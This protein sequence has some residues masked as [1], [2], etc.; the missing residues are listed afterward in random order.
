MQQQMDQIDIERWR[1]VYKSVGFSWGLVHNLPAI[2]LQLSLFCF[3]WSIVSSRLPPGAIWQGMGDPLLSR[4][5]WS[6]MAPYLQ[7]HLMIH[8]CMEGNEEKCRG[9]AGEGARALV[10]KPLSLTANIIVLPW[11][12][13]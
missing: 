1:T 5:F 10:Q 9:S 6:L 3:N 4:G 8:Q 2:R 13:P 11:R 7:K 12:T